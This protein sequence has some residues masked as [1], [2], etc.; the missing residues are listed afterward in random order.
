LS[1]QRTASSATA[2]DK[3]RR[4]SRP[5]HSG[6]LRLRLPSAAIAMGALQVRQ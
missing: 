5:L 4:A 3:K 2:T 1:L 6:A